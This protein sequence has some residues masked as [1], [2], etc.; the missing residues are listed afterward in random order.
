MGTGPATRGWRRKAVT[1]PPGLG[2]PGTP[3]A[4]SEPGAAASGPCASTAPRPALVPASLPPVS[5]CSVALSPEDS[6]SPSSDIS[7]ASPIWR[8]QK[9]AQV[10]DVRLG[11][12][13]SPP[14]RGLHQTN[15]QGLGDDGPPVPLTP[16]EDSTCRDPRFHTPLLL[17][18]QPLPGRLPR[19]C[20]PDGPHLSLCLVCLPA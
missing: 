9:L 8:V 16:A 17:P 6:R 5:L 11:V 4:F 7:H 2:A 15:L 13:A 18:S 14:I 20:P 19:P 3:R 1:A 12:G 10:R